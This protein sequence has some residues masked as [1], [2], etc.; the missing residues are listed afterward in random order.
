M[1]N[2]ERDIDQPPTEERAGR[3]R[4][5][6]QKHTVDHEGNRVS[7]DEDAS[8]PTREPTRDQQQ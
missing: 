2:D 6:I 8:Q 5:R 1:R 7:A 4:H 3:L